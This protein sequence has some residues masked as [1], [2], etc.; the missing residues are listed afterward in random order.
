M[1]QINNEYFSPEE[2]ETEIFEFEYFGN[3]RI[4]EGGLGSGFKLGLSFGRRQWP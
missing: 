4:G 3:V 2:N 1:K